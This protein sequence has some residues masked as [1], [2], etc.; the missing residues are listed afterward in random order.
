MSALAL[1]AKRTIEAAWAL[2]PAYD[3]GSQAA[4]ALESAQLLQPPKSAE[5]A[6]RQ[7]L[8]LVVAEGDLLNMRGSLSPNGHPRR[9]PMELG[10][11]VAPAVDWLLAEVERLQ[12][13]VTELE[14]PDTGTEYGIRA[15]G[16]VMDIRSGHGEDLLDRLTREDQECRVARYRDQYPDAVLVT[17][18]ATYSEWTEAES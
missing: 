9:V 17:R 14:A 5:R 3:L 7:R 15:E 2:G 1:T 8:R 16:R 11:R 13:R 18:T 6:E 4:F 12:K 10:D